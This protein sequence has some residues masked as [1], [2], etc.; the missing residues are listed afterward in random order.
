MIA[1][2]REK[3]GSG[4]TCQGYLVLKRTGMGSKHRKDILVQLFR[5]GI[6][7]VKTGLV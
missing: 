5:I 4:L 7:K 1:G 6:T 2:E 3:Y